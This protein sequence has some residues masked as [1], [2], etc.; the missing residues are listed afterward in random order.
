VPGCP[1]RENVHFY[2]RG[3]R[4]LACGEQF[5]TVEIDERHLRAYVALREYYASIRRERRC[6]QYERKKRIEAKKDLK[7]ALPQEPLVF[8]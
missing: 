3:R 6:R 8:D 7:D 1:E 5:V 4:C 2:R